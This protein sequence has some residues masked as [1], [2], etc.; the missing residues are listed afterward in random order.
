MKTKHGLGPVEKTAR[1]FDL[2]VLKTN[3]T[4]IDQLRAELK[5]AKEHMWCAYCGQ[6]FHADDAKIGALSKHIASCEKHPM[7]KL[8]NDYK[9]IREALIALVDKLEKVHSHPDYESIWRTA[10]AQLGQ[11]TGPTYTRE[12]ES[13]ANLLYSTETS[14]GG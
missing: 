4:E 14:L 8:E 11:Y 1:G 10:Y 5:D 7:R 3:K 2:I 9:I 12:L 13:A 6:E